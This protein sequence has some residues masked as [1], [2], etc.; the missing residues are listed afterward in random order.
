MKKV[1]KW[2]TK[3]FEAPGTKSTCSSECRRSFK[4]KLKTLWYRK[5]EPAHIINCKVCG[6]EFI[7]I[8]GK[9]AYCSK[10]CK[11]EGKAAYM[12]KYSELDSYKA[13][14]KKRNNTEAYRQSIKKYSKS[15]KCKETLLKRRATS[16]KY[17]AYLKKRRALKAGATIGQV[18]YGWINN[19]GGSRCGICG[20]LVN[21]GLRHPDPMSKSYDHI[22]PLTLGGEHSNRN[23]QLTH[24]ICNVRKN[25]RIGNGV[26]MYLL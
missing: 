2:C 18:D 7:R 24:N 9:K 14:I 1:C 22:V 10:E 16:V 3:P 20:E 15:S 17:R 13:Y 19:R 5:T 25:N 11:R 8:R 26:Q 4:N 12:R 6:K 21:L 23:L